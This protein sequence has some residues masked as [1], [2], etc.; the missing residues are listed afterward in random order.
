ADGYGVGAVANDFDGDGVN[1]LTEYAMDG[2]PTN[3]LAPTSLPVFS[4]VGNGFIYV[5]PQRS[6]DET[7]IYTVETTTNLIDGVWTDD[8]YTVI[9]TDVT[10]GTLNFVTNEVDAVENEKFIRLKIEQ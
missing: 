4:R 5:H 7:L 9:G 8:G 3:G 6:D 2:N 10:G 1:N